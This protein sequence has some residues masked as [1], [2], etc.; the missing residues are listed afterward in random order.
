MNGINSKNGNIDPL[1]NNK[2]SLQKDWS[3]EYEELSDLE[4]TFFVGGKGNPM[5]NV[6][7]VPGGGAYYPNGGDN[8][9]YGGISEG[10]PHAG[11]SRKL[12]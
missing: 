8:G 1:V 9:V 12:K 4:L 10:T 5:K 6:Q 3:L 2:D 11:Y 7:K